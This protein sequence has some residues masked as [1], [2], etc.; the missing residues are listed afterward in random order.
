LSP[1][2]RRPSARGHRL[3]VQRYL[4]HFR[5]AGEVVLFGRS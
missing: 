5:A 2:R 3:Y 4:S 1:C